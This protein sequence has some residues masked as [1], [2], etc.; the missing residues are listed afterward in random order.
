MNLDKIERLRRYIFTLFHT[1]L[2]LLTPKE[3][4]SRVIEVFIAII[5]DF[6][7]SIEGLLSGAIGVYADSSEE[8]IDS[9]ATLSCA[10][11]SHA[12]CSESLFVMGILLYISREDIDS[13]LI[14]EGLESVFER[15]VHRY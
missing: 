13:L 3:T 15:L 8:I 12:A 4:S 9:E 14:R 1:Y 5:E 11:I 6:V 10:P 2:H 7:G